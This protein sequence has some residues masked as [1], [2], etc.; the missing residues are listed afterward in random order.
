VKPLV[1]MRAALGD[2]DLL[3]RA[4]PGE[5]WSAWRTML[6]AIMGEELRPDEREVFTELT[7]GREAEPV[8]LVRRFSLLLADGLARRGQRRLRASIWRRCAIILA[9]L[10]LA[11]AGC[12]RS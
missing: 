5:S 11:S 8:S 9:S 1:S 12:F 7:G 3:G 6:I 2:P 4:L 10:L